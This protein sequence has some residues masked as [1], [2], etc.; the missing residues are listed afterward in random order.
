[1]VAIGRGLLAICVGVVGAAWVSGWHPAL[2]SLGVFLI[3]AVATAGA[4]SLVFAIARCRAATA[5][6]VLTLLSGGLVLLQVGLAPRIDPVGN[7]RLFQHNLLHSS[8]AADLMARGASTDVMTLQEVQRSRPVVA[9]PPAPWR[10]R[11]CAHSHIGDVAVISRWPIVAHG[12][13]DGAVWARVRTPDGPVTFVSVHLR[14]PWPRAQTAQ[15]DG[16]VPHLRALPRP[17][18]VAGDFN[19]VTWSAAMARIAQATDTRLVPGLRV[20][21]R[22][23]AGT[24]RVPIDHVL[25]PREWD[26]TARMAGAYG[27]DHRSLRARIGPRAERNRP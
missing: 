2:D 12:C 6:S 19:H 22:Q 7:I 4:L 13:L 25:I 11:I 8:P 24:L 20:T 9:R 21:L 10:S 3:Y 18:V 27:S 15:I 1:M 5:V 14:W 26:G 16:L 23:F 17:V